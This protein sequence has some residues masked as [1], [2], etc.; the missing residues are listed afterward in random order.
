MVVKECMAAAAAIK[1]CRGERLGTR[2]RIEP[3]ESSVKAF[4]MA[5]AFL[6]GIWQ[7]SSANLILYLAA[8]RDQMQLANPT[9]Q[10]VDSP[11]SR[12]AHRHER[13]SVG[14]DH[15]VPG[16]PSPDASIGGSGGESHTFPF[17]AQRAVVASDSP[18]R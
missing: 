1:E 9:E 7:H 4:E 6:F 13:S 14:R 5:L 16:V 10:R 12:R 3:S 15:D 8:A 11:L 2:C 18:K 17:H